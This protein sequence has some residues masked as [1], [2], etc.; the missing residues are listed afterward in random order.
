MFTGRESEVLVV[1][2]FVRVED[3]VLG[4]DGVSLLLDV[5]A[6]GWVGDDDWNFLADGVLFDFPDS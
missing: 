4:W 3:L 5:D 2:D 1:K 6:L